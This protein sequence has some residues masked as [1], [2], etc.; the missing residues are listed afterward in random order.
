[1]YPIARPLFLFTNGYPKLGTPLHG[2]VTLY[3]SEKG[4]EIV[5]AIGFVPVTDY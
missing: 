3:L 2:F 1:V 4:Q 5:E